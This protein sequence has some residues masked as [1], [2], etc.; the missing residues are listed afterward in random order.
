MFVTVKRFIKYV[1]IFNLLTLLIGDF[2]I[3]KAGATPNAS[4]TFFGSIDSYLRG[5]TG[6][7]S[8][9]IY[10]HSSQQTLTLRPGT[11][12]HAAS[13]AK[14]DLMAAYLYQLQLHN[15][16]PSQSDYSKLV[17]MI[18]FSNN[19]D[20]AYF[21]RLVGLCQGLT[22]FNSLI[23]LESTTPVCPHGSIYGWGITNTTALDQLKV[24]SLFSGPN[25][26]LVSSSRILGLNLMRHISAGDTWGVST[27]PLSQSEVAFKNGWSP[28]TSNSDWQINSIG[29]VN[30]QN[31]NYDVAI[32]TSHAP[33]FSYGVA[34]TNRVAAM[35]WNQLA[36][37][38]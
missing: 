16:E 8:I 20:A 21:Y 38:P 19:E 14:V 29:W 22:K 23:P 26:I 34:T 18:E 33:S 15:Q 4:A 5:R 7:T 35:I 1:L 12:N 27:G 3:H 37:A 28:L 17:G 10:V 30:S 36:P 9:A 32:M 31:R 25:A 13:V 11:L 6:V 2:S 24:M